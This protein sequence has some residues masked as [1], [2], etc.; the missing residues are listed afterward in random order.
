MFKIKQPVREAFAILSILHLIIAI[1][2][3]LRNG[4]IEWILY[5]LGDGAV[6][7]SILCEGYADDSPPS[8]KKRSKK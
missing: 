4:K 2:V 1:I 3:A 6:V 8:H 5:A 7:F